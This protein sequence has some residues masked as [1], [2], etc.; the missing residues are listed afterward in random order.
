MKKF[1]I[2]ACTLI[3]NACTFTSAGM[4]SY[5]IRPFND[6]AGKTVCCEVKVENGK[7]YATLHAKVKKVGEDWEVELDEVGVAAFKGQELTTGVVTAVADA[8]VKA[9]TLSPGK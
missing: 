9:M 7:E 3:L 8:V 2:A 1:L 6:G 4:A 5:S